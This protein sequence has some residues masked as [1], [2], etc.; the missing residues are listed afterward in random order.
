MNAYF[1]KQKKTSFRQGCDENIGKMV[2]AKT[3][4]MARHISNMNVRDEGKIWTDT[5]LV[6]CSKISLD[7]E[8]EVIS[9][10]TSG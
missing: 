3:E 9:I 7:K 6:S 4:T 8:Y 10:G 5:K 2:V 1:L